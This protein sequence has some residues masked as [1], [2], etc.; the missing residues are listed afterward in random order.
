MFIQLIDGSV[1]LAKA[2]IGIKLEKSNADVFKGCRNVV[3]ITMTGEKFYSGFL[4]EDDAKELLSKY[5]REW[6][7]YK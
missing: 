4:K 7:G 6:Q 1:V 5:V 3:V 2:V